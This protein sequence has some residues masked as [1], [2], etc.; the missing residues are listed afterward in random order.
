M[1]WTGGGRNRV[2]LTDPRNLLERR[3]RH[4]I[5]STKSKTTKTNDNNGASAV[6]YNSRN[7]HDRVE[8]MGSGIDIGGR[9][10]RRQVDLPYHVYHSHLGERPSYARNY[11]V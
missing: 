5:S 11:L 9:R 8:F 4:N 7:G 1:N 6:V 2:T 3:S 10:M